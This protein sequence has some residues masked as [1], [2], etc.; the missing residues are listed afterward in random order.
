MAATPMFSC[1]VEDRVG[2]TLQLIAMFM[3]RH[4]QYDNSQV[5]SHDQI[6]VLLSNILILAG[7][8]GM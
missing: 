7:P 8:R 4:F 6:S 3:L 5:S 2:M 1:G